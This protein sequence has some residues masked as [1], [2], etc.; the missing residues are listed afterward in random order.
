METLEQFKQKFFDL[1][2]R[3]FGETYVEPILRKVL[4]H[5][6]HEGS[7]YDA[8]QDGKRIE[9]KAV[10]VVFT[11]KKLKKS[12]MYDRV[13]SNSHMSE[14]I[15]TLRD[16]ADGKI[17]ANCQ[18]IKLDEFDVLVYVLV[19]NDGFHIFRA[20]TEM[21]IDGVFPNWCPNHGSKEKGKN[22]QFPI[23][24]DNIDWHIKNCYPQTLCWDD[25]LKLS[26]EIKF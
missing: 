13:L 17:V 10:R 16:I 9:Y 26:K 4:N 25:V 20:K 11:A 14:R 7:E 3:V 15:G 5:S 8:V 21:F 1:P 12:L 6:S 2:S 22:G 23:K 24:G 18:N 19:D